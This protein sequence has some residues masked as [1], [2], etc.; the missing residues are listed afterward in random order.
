MEGTAPSFDTVS[1]EQ[2]AMT[3][4]QRMKYASQRLSARVLQIHKDDEGATRSLGVTPRTPLRLGGRRRM[5][6]WAVQPLA[7]RLSVRLRSETSS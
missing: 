6:S 7:L 2:R 5:R 4:E 1:K 3:K